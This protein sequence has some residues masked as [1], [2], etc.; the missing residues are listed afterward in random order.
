VFA[1][2]LRLKTAIDERDG[3]ESISEE[4]ETFP[5]LIHKDNGLE[6]RGEF[7]VFMQQHHIK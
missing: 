6:F 7:E 5:R 1:R 2:P 3:M 4:A